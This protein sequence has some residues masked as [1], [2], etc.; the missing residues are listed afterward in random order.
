MSQKLLGI[1]LNDHLAGAIVGTELAKRA[2]RNNQGMP[3]GKFLEDLCEDIEEDRITLESVMDDLGIPKSRIKE[4]GAWIAEKVGRL[5]LNG[6]FSG[7][8]DLSRVLE[9]EGLTLGV[10][11]KLSMWRSLEQVK[12]TYPALQRIDLDRLI[13][14]AQAQARDLE[15]HRRDAASLAF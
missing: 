11:G 9:L 5:K 2:A 15:E 8:S 1:Y 12:D 14:R 7:Y 13:E 10:E 4:V 6:Q 3:L